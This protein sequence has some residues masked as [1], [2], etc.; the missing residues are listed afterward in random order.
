MAR[1][2][3][4]VDAPSEQ[5]EADR[6]DGVPHPRHTETL[7]GHDVCWQEFEHAAKADR[8][9]HAWL[10]TGP[11]GVGK[12]TFA[13]KAARVLLKDAGPSDLGGGQ[14]DRLVGAM[15]HPRLLVVR[16]PFDPKTKKFTSVIPV[17]EVR[18]LK[19][20]V[21]KSAD[22]KSWRVVIIDDANDLNIAAANAL[23]KVLEEPPRQT[24]FLLVAPQPGALLATIRSRCRSLAFEPLTG[25][26]FSDALNQALRN[27]DRNGSEAPA[28]N[29]AELEQLEILSG[30]SVRRALALMSE[31]GMHLVSEISEQFKRLPDVEWD[32]LRRFA[33][34]ISGPGQEGRF[35]LATSLILEKLAALIKARASNM[36]PAGD[37]E[38][39]R[40]LI[41]T[42][43][44][45]SW[46]ELWERVWRDRAQTLALNL[47]KKTFVLTLFADLSAS[48]R[49]A[50]SS[51]PDAR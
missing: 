51:K 19:P 41:D 3:V 1:G 31:D 46:A 48:A 21:A 36:G 6:L 23:L 11:E 18:K 10:L 9:H 29:I 8:L 30:G 45:A 5:P 13:Y 47:D 24:V 12:A 20:F 2:P 15:A 37:V 22:R 7:F 35:E 38:L 40:R 16:R 50:V 33:E 34:T 27:G 14:S 26:Q 25:S 42:G 49:E 43:T 17:D 39:A 32:N 4:E 28:L 44:V